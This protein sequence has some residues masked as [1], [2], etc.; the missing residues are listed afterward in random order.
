MELFPI[1][2]SEATAGNSALLHPTPRHRNREK[3][4]ENS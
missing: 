1:S 4:F 3:F 2:E